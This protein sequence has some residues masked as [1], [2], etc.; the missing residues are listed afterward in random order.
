MP[1]TNGNKHGRG[2]IVGSRNKPYDTG[3]RLFLE[4]VQSVVATRF[5]SLVVSIVSDL[6]GQDAL[7]AGELQLVRRCAMISVQCEVME[8]QAAANQTFDVTAYGTLT[9]HLT[10]AL[11]AIGL[12]RV[13]RDIT[14]TLQKYLEA[15]ATKP[16]EDEEERKEPVSAP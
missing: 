9:G 5:R 16:D 13:P 3:R 11:K 4:E 1:F 15:A 10:R 12:K 6:G 14:P 8:Q 2:R 7:S